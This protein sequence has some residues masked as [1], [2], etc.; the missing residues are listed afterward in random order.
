MSYSTL[1]AW[2]LAVLLVAG[3]FAVDRAHGQDRPPIAD[4]TL[5]AEPGHERPAGGEPAVAGL[6]AGSSRS[7]SRLTT[8]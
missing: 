6:G 8:A 2:L 4:S 5:T 7:Y 1:A 3:T